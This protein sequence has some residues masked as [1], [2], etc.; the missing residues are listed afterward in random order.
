MQ[1][2]NDAS[3]EAT[4][5]A[6]LQVVAVGLEPSRKEE[7]GLKPDLHHSRWSEFIPTS[8]SLGS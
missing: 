6:T 4:I 2:S 1:S 3:D 8:R 7:V 5:V